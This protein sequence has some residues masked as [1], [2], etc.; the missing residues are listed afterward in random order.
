MKIML[1]EDDAN[2]RSLLQMLLEMD[3]HIITP[4]DGKI[5]INDILNII[6]KNPPDVLIMDV[7]L[8]NL[9]GIELLKAIRKQLTSNQLRVIMTSGMNLEKECINA[10]ADN[11]LM[12]PYIPDVLLKLL[13]P[14][15]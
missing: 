3:G 12:K 1:I 14:G 7:H 15:E 2:M 13:S 6:Q 8:P 4:Y 10:G 9:N 11:F 5:S